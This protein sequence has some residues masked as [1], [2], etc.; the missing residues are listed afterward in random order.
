MIDREHTGMA[1]S[2]RMTQRLRLA[3]LVMIFF[4]SGF[5]AMLYQLV[6]QR[7]LFTMYGINVEAVAVVV[8]GFM[9]GL[10]FGSMLGG[11]LSKRFIGNQI[12]LF[13]VVE[14]GIGILGYSSLPVFDAVS[15]W[16]LSMS[17]VATSIVSVSLLLMPTLLMGAT[18]PLLVSHVVTQSGNVGRSVGLL[19]FANTMGSA[20]GCFAAAVF[21]MGQF[22]MD[23]STHVAASLNIA[24]GTGGFIAW[25][26]HRRA[27]PRVAPPSADSLMRLS[28]GRYPAGLALA[29][30]TGFL[31]L[32]YEILWFRAVSIASGGL[33]QAFAVTLGAYLGGIAIGSVIGRRWCSDPTGENNRHLKAL[34]VV[35]LTSGI[36][37]QVLVPCVAEVGLL[38]TGPL[39]VA[40]IVL[41]AFHGGLS[42]VAFPL[43]CHHGVPPNARAG[44]SLAGIYMANIIGSALGSVLTGFI[45]VDLLSTQNV[46]TTLAVAG[47]AFGLF[48]IV[49]AGMLRW[50]AGAAAAVAIMVAMAV[51]APAIWHDVWEKLIFARSYNPASPFADI[52]E[53][54]SGVIAVTKDRGVYGGGMYD[55]RITTDA[56]AN[57]NGIHRPVAVPAFHSR[58]GRVLM[59]GLSTGAWAE[60]LAHLDTL[61]R[62]D[63]VEINPGYLRLIARYPEVRDVLTNPKVSIIID[64][65]R[66][67]LNRNPGAR[68]DMIIQNTTFYFR[69]NV[70]NLLSREYLGIVSRHLLPD[71]FFY[72]N[73]QG[74]ARVQR[75]ACLVKPESIRFSSMMILPADRIFVDP[76]RWAATAAAWRLGDRSL[77]DTGHEGGR[78]RLADIKASL[79]PGSPELETCESILARSAEDLPM[80]DRNMG[81]EWTSERG[82]HDAMLI[83]L[84]SHLRW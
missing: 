61:E 35:L 14:L 45:M 70:T 59:I 29:G 75:T 65:G 58:P 72:Y 23:G 5:P 47:A 52:V 3:F 31:S 69:S 37:G 82:Q 7:C 62:M 1:L 67:W 11:W 34:A 41:I 8:T 83:W 54:K 17:A 36:L 68:Y 19:Y 74:S 2:V 71:G 46:S 6:W 10:G 64:D 21:V 76:D 43:I 4:I 48:V 51:S 80:T 33:A 60:I 15:T 53:N 26:M 25:F 13:A 24:V 40:A 27:A 57:L 20:V 16:T 79:S 9:L 28:P 22:G 78:K 56:V 12:L 81:A 39:M 84:R 63:I 32:S 42:G 50:T 38:G 66:K 18:L 30:G 49:Q 73:T 44:S 55:G 77:L